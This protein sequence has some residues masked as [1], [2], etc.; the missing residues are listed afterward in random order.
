[1]TAR[2]LPNLEEDTRLL[3][4]LTSLHVRYIG[5]DYATKNSVDGQVSRHMIDELSAKSFP[6]CMRQ[7]HEAFRH[8]HHLRY[9]GRLQYTLFLKGIGMTLEDVLTMW[10]EEFSKI[11]DVDKVP[12]ENAGS[13]ML[14]SGFSCF[15]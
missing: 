3:P 8:N 2:L 5:D 7:L 9:G 4:M 15:S 12:N 14:G 10:R 6:L 11:M 1:M 13:F